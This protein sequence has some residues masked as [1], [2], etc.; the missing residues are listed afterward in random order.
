MGSHIFVWWIDGPQQDVAVVA[1]SVVL[2]RPSQ[3][4]QRR[5]V[6]TEQAC[7]IAA[8]L[9]PFL[10]ASPVIAC[11]GEEGEQVDKVTLERLFFS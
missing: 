2:D 10:G 5:R 1:G 8:V 9:G 11:R 3:V 4:S 6:S 7:H